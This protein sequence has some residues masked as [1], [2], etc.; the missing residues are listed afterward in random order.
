MIE[1]GKTY[2]VAWAAPGC[3]FTTEAFATRGR[4]RTLA[5]V[6]DCIGASAAPGLV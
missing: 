6:D 3:D 1:K 2:H 5:Y 4:G